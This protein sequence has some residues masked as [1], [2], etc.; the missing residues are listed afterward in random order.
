M[1]E[2]KGSIFDGPTVVVAGTMVLFDALDVVS[3]FTG[4]GPLALDG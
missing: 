2:V 4:L 1:T 3:G